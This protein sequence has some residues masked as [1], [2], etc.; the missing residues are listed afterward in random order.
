[1]K[2]I[3]GNSLTISNLK[4]ALE[5]MKKPDLLPGG[6]ELITH[7]F[8]DDD[9]LYVM[10]KQDAFSFLD[11]RKPEMVIPKVEFD[12]NVCRS[13]YTIEPPRRSIIDYSTVADIQELCKA[14]WVELDDDFCFCKVCGSPRKSRLVKLNK[15]EDD[16]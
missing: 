14:C 5:K 16:G 8:L 9:K 3:L 10:E 2:Q 6:M 4:I 7:D 11:A 13:I 12:T 1:M 15:G